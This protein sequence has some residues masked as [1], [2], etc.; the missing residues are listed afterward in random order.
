MKKHLRGLFW[1]LLIALCIVRPAAAEMETFTDSIVNAKALAD[2]P[3]NWMPA[4]ADMFKIAE[5]GS[6]GANPYGLKYYNNQLIVRTSSKEV[7]YNGTYGAPTTAGSNYTIY[8]AK[9]ILSNWVT[10]G[11]GLTS[12]IDSQGLTASTMI[13]GVER[14]LGMNNTGAHDAIFE[15]AVTVGNAANPYLL[16][17]V[18]NP[19]PTTFG[20]NPANYGTNGAFPANAAAAGIGTGAAADAVFA[21]YKTAYEAWAQS[22]HSDPKES[23]RFPWTELGYTY[24]WGQAENVPTRLSEVQGMSEFILLGGAGGSDPLKTP[25]GTNESGN[26]IVVGIYA[27]QSYI[28]T[29]NDGTTFSDA[30][31]AQ[32]G[33]GFA[34]FNVTGPCNTLWAGP[35]FQVGASMDSLVPNIIT[36]GT[37]GSISGGQGILVDSRHYMVTN[38]GTITANADTKK[39]NVAGSENIALLFTGETHA[40]PDASSRQNM[41]INRGAIIGPGDRGV[42]VASWGGYTTILN[43]GTITGAGYGIQTQDVSDSIWVHGGEISGGTAAIQTGD[44]KTYVTLYDG[45]ISGGTTAIETGA[46]KDRITVEAGYISGGRTAIQTF[47][48][49]DRILIKGGEISGGEYGIQSGGGKDKVLIRGGIVSGGITA[50][51]TGAG[52][53]KIKVKKGAVSGG[54]FAVQ[55]GAGD[56][57]LTVDG[58]TISGKIDMGKGADVFNVTG[59]KNATFNFTLN[60][61]A[62]DSAQIANTETVTIADGTTIAVKVSETGNIRNNDQFL[63]TKAATLTVDPAKLAIVNDPAL[64]MVTFSAD[65]SGKKLYLT[66]LRDSVFYSRQIP[67]SSMGSVLDSLANTAT[68]DMATVLGALDSS[69]SAGSALQLEPNVNNGAVQASFG[70][71]SQHTGTVI[72]RI[73]QVFAAR[74]EGTAVTG[75]STG[76]ETA[77]NGAWAQGFGSYLNQANIGTS[78]GYTANVW[79]ISLGYDRAFLNNAL[80]GF[81]LGF[82]RNNITTNDVNTRTDADSYQGSLY[83]SLAGDAHYLDAVLSFAYNRYDASRHIAFPGINRI[84][85]GNYGGR[86]YSGYFEGGY[87]FKASGFLLTPLAS[88]HVMRL[89]LEDYTETDAGALNLKMDRQRYNL[90]QTGIGAKIAWPILKKGLKV[91]PEIHAKWLYDFAGDAQQATSTFTGGGA[92]FVTNGVEPPK[93]SGNL[94]AKLT[95][96]TQSGWSV[97]LNY[98]F[99]MKTDFYSHNGW[100]NLRYEF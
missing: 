65:K 71:V 11:N 43:T 87:T 63:I 78:G 18:R 89:D 36:I 29:K 50:I 56:D 2:A 96:L 70:T 58:G 13:K 62:A 28:Y 7:N 68:G 69:G 53:D 14:G 6:V 64:P 84:A 46:G 12:F 66:A 80:A 10:T 37:G 44:A 31:D 98:D 21:N 55:T 61:D 94:G 95:L 32:Y 75:I 22:S 74:T 67:N 42:G 17:P 99:E 38:Y 27:T 41:L 97:S 52:D 49:K 83:G 77:Q 73:S 5:S 92:S 54:T 4:N 47:G 19:D 30:P 59:N 88:L 91:T 81:S 93:S 79:G 20:A 9:N 60:R 100:V 82:A 51:E 3:A 76:S 24:Y 26:V 8:G 23:N 90:F 48:G 45:R 16:R 1:I 85:H 39:F 35:S 57:T 40:T 15:M 34:S 72:G 33:N 25:S 86:Q